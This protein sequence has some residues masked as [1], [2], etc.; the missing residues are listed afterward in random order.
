MTLFLSIQNTYNELE[1]ALIRDE[2][3]LISL[4][5]DKMRA[6][7]DLIPLVNYVCEKTKI[8]LRDLNFIAVNQGPGPFTTLRVVIASVNGLAYGAKIPLVGIDGLDALLLEHSDPAYPHTI[9]LLNAFT[10]DVYFGIQTEQTP[11][12]ANLFN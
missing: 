8:H 5:D 6:S 12:F 9:A 2:T 3:V 1:L 11:H 7:K 10:N 4:A